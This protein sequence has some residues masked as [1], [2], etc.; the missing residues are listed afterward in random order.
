MTLTIH[1]NAETIKDK[2][3]IIMLKFSVWDNRDGCEEMEI[4]LEKLVNE[5]K[6]SVLIMHGAILIERKV[7]GIEIISVIKYVIN[8]RIFLDFC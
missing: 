8:F 7:L 5:I 3:I 2:E 4:P 1:I 6:N